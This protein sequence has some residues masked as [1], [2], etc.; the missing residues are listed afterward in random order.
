MLILIFSIVK[1]SPGNSPIAWPKPLKMVSMSPVQRK[2]KCHWW[3]PMK[4]LFQTGLIERELNLTKSYHQVCKLV[5][6]IF[7]IYI[8][9][10]IWF[11]GLI[12]SRIQKKKLWLSPAMGK[13]TPPKKLI[14]LSL[15]L[16]KKTYGFHPV[17]LTFLVM[18]PS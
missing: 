14:L 17:D 18:I 4:M 13:F 6:Y 2:Y 9:F 12:L 3:S 1:L 5:Y 16:N 15:I 11:K 8:Y 10:K 7:L